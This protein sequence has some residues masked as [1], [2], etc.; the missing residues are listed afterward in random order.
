MPSRKPESVDLQK[1]ACSCIWFFIIT[2]SSLSS[3]HLPHLAD[4]VPIPLPNEG[5]QWIDQPIVAYEFTAFR[6]CVNRH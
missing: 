3:L 1:A 6:T 2:D 5:T 4:A